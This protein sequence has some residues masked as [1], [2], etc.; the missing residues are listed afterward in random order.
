MKTLILGDSFSNG[1][2]LVNTDNI[3]WKQIDPNATCLAEVGDANGTI[4]NKFLCNKDFDRVIVMWTFSVRFDFSPWCI[5]HVHDDEPKT[6]DFKKLWYSNI[7]GD[8]TYVKDHCWRNIYTLQS[9]LKDA[10]ID[11]IFCFA[12]FD[13]FRN[14]DNIYKKDDILYPIDW[15]NFFFIDELN[16]FCQWAIKNN[17]SIGGGGHPI[18]DANIEYGKQLKEWNDKRIYKKL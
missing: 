18:D 15:D 13:I 11:Y 6:I 14:G 16:G 17:Y 2:E 3:W 4:L 12:D 8:A 9:L 1:C 5:L 10:N 7:G